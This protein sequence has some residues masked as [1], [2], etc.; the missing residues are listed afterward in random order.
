MSKD[1]KQ[2]IRRPH[3]ARRTVGMVLACVFLAVVIAA[4]VAVSMLGDVS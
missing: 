2:K 3:Q 1:K 4:N